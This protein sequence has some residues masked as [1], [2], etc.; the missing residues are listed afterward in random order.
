MSKNKNNKV[1]E[2]IEEFE[3]HFERY[4]NEDWDTLTLL[5]KERCVDG[6]FIKIES[7]V[8]QEEKERMEMWAKGNYSRNAQALFAHLDLR[9][10]LQFLKEN[11]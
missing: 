2:K 5:E 4:L 7:R 11:R 9:D 1:E 8:K 3:A 6:F 10:F